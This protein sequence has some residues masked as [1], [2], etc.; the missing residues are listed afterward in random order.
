[1]AGAAIALLG[2]LAPALGSHLTITPNYNATLDGGTAISADATHGAAIEAA[3]NAA[4]AVYESTFSNPINVNINFEETTSGLGESSTFLL[5]VTYASYR[6][7][8]ISQATSS[9]QMT[10]DATLPATMTEPVKGGTN[11]YITT[12]DAKALGYVAGYPAYDSTI[13]LNTA[14]LSYPGGPALSPSNYDLHA[15][16]SHEIDEALA[17]G[18]ALNDP[19]D[20]PIRAEDL[21]R[22]SAQGIRSYTLSASATDYFSIDG[23]KTNIAPFNQAGGGSDYGDWAT[24][25]TPRV[26]DAFGSPGVAINLGP[27]EFTAL[28]VLGYNFIQQVP[29]PGSLPL[30]ILGLA[31]VGGAAWRKSR[32]SRADS[33]EATRPP[34]PGGAS[35]PI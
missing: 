17:T 14:L 28:N 15:V 13:L 19:S 2:Q 25:S 27:A 1:M 22:Y 16:V 6:S 12:A 32:R 29:E 33:P 5:P 18:S 31:G 3:I 34:A 24:T 7:A 23:G 30:L 35:N 10:A 26:Q 11:I 21:F 9:N 4:I 8:L 20:V